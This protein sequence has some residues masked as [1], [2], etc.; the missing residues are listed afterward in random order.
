MDFSLCL[1]VVEGA[2]ELFGALSIKALVRF[3]RVLLPNT[4]MLYVRISTHAF[5]GTR[6]FRP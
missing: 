6:T 3:M 4:I 5:E 2:M 1:Q